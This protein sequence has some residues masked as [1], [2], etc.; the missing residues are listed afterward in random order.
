MGINGNETSPVQKKIAHINIFNKL[1]F[2][3]VIYSLKNECL[4]D[5]TVSYKELKN[6]TH[7]Q[8]S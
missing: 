8:S 4:I 7:L 5:M 1:I 3:I 2:V 6:W